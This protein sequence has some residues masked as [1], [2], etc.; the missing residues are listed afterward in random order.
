MDQ[1]NLLD[2]TLTK[3]RKDE[4][5]AVKRVAE[6]QRE[7]AKAQAELS[8]A[9]ERLEIVRGGKKYV[10]FQKQMVAEKEDLC[11]RIFKTFFPRRDGP[12]RRTILD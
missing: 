11:E 12:E 9:K 2:Q 8:A 1:R 7:A 6:A 3:L 10:L 5:D 4:F